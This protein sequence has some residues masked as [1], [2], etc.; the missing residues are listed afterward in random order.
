MITRWMLGA[1]WAAQAAQMENIHQPFRICFLDCV[2]VSSADSPTN[3][4][5]R[6]FI[7]TNNPGGHYTLQLDSPSLTDVQEHVSC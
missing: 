4:A 7:N 6:Q 1:A 2:M 5:L 3:S